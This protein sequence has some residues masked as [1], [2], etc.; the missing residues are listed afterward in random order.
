MLKRS[1]TTTSSGAFKGFQTDDGARKHLI[2]ANPIIKCDV[3]KNR[4]C[5]GSQAAQ[6]PSAASM[7]EFILQI[8]SN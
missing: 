2:T 4:A 7:L 8:N 3:G 1:N 6:R 5:E